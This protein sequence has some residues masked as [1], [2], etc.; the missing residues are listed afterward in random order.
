MKTEDVKKLSPEERLLYWINERESIRRKKT[1]GLPAPWTDDEILQTYRFTCVRRMDDKVSDWLLRNW[2]R[3]YKDHENIVLAAVLARMLNNTESLTEIGFPKEWEPDSLVEKLNS[4]VVRG[5]KNF[6]GAYMITGTLGGTKVEQVIYKVADYM[7]KNP[8]EIDGKSMEEAV[9]S[10]IPYPGFSSFMAGQ[11]V[12][13]LRWAMSGAWADKRRWAP[14]GPG[15]KR[16]MNRLKERPTDALLS[17][18]QFLGELLEMIS[19]LESKLPKDLTKRLEAIDYQSCL[20]ELDK[21]TRALL[22]EGRPKQLYK[23]DL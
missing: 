2:Y 23:G 6:S 13:D 7:Y 10:L 18:G 20:C 19:W 4:R 12:A 3:P 22:G 15:S 9:K 1:L 16:G 21:Y 11:V 8:L 5:L 14:I 17:Q